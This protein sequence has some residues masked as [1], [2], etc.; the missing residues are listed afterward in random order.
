MRYK[1]S[2][3][4]EYLFHTFG[5]D[6]TKA[7]WSAQTIIRNAGCYRNGLAEEITLKEDPSP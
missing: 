2:W 1:I 4:D 7:K 6:E 5:D 3:N